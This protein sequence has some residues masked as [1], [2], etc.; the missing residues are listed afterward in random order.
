MRG[1][2]EEFFEFMEDLCQKRPE[3][4]EM[5]PQELIDF[6]IMEQV[7]K[8]VKKF[9]EKLNEMQ[10]EIMETKEE[11]IKKCE[12]VYKEVEQYSKPIKNN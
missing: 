10:K 9:G 11:V 1:D 2:Q 3:F 5:T 4:L 7:I 6:I 8:I 12:E